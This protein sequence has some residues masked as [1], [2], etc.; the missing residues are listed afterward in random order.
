MG[1]LGPNV[2]GRLVESRMDLCGETSYPSAV[3]N[4]YALCDIHVV[5]KHIRIFSMVTDVIKHYENEIVILI[6]PT[7]VYHRLQLLN[8]DHIIL[9]TTATFINI[10]W[11]FPVVWFMY[12][13]GSDICAIVFR[14]NCSPVN[15]V[16]SVSNLFSLCKT[17]QE[18]DDTFSIIGRVDTIC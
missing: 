5:L 12:G 8:S 2:C 10:L 9:W 15:D 1:L 18:L 4:Q 3:I 13:K 11:M 7:S 14:W 17:T 16:R 6:T